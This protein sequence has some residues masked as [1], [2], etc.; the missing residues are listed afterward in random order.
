MFNLI[1]FDFPGRE[2]GHGLS[3]SFQGE[4]SQVSKDVVLVQGYTASKV[5]G[6]D[7]TQIQFDLFGNFHSAAVWNQFNSQAEYQNFRLCCR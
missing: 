2:A 7:R 6:E 3:S 4:E 1:G 5:S